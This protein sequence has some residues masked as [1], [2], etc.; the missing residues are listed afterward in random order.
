MSKKMDCFIVSGFLG[1]GK[2]TFVNQLLQLISLQKNVAIAINDFGKINLDM[3]LVNFPEE[4]IISLKKGCMCCSLAAK[5]IIDFDKLYEAQP[6]VDTFIIEA[7]GITSL[8]SLIHIIKSDHMKSKLNLTHVITTVN[9]SNF[10]R[11]HDKLAIV[12]QQVVMANTIVLNFKDQTSPDLYKDTKALISK[13]NKQATIFDTSF[14]QIPVNILEQPNSLI[15][16]QYSENSHNS[17]EMFTGEIM[18]SGISNTDLLASMLTSLPEHIYRAKG[19]IQTKNGLQLIEKVDKQIT[20]LPFLTKLDK[21]NINTIV[22]IGWKPL[23][24]AINKV[25]S[26]LKNA[27]FKSRTNT[28]VH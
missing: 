25:I 13:L 14:S 15:P 22:L 7:S 12:K 3:S 16:T 1:S 11:I 23:D 9:A 24:N 4:R 6:T 18:L 26:L 19:I 27:E 10:I 17:D 21:T 5:F 20:C 28:H 2:T 8:E